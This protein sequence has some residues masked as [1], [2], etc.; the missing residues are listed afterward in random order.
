MV[1]SKYQFPF[2]TMYPGQA[3]I[4]SKVQDNSSFCM[5]PHTGFGKTPCFL[6]L[7]RDTASIV[8]EPRKF[9]QHQCSVSYYKD[10]VLYGRSGY[11]CTYSASKTAAS[12]PCLLKIECSDTTYHDTCPNANKTCLNDSC[13]I[14]PVGTTYKRYPCDTCEYISAQKEALSVLRDNGTVICNF[15]NFW[16]LLKSAKTVVIDEADLFFREISA[17]VAVRYTKPKDLKDL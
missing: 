11:A 4:L 14:F 6:S 1:P 10:F 13:K 7:T 2:P 3:D 12:A 8:I 15:G 16:N 9:L 5:T 17:P